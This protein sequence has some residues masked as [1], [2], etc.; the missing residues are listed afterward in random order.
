[1]TPPDIAL[2]V[3]VIASLKIHVY[4]VTAA[5]VR[6]ATTAT[7]KVKVLVNISPHCWREQ[8]WLPAFGIEEVFFLNDTD[9]S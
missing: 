3:L 7:T 8:V 1:M 5:G 4:G 2:A 6:G 9:W